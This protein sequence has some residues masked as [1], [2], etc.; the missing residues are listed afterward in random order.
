[1]SITHEPTAIVPAEGVRA[2]YNETGTA[3]ATGIFVKDTAGSTEDS[4]AVC[5]DGEIAKGVTM[6]AIADLARGDVQVS[7]RAVMT[8]G[9]A[10]AR[11]VEV[12]ANASG[13]AITAVSGDWVAGRSVSAAGALADEITIELLGP[14]S[15]YF[16]A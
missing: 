12:T 9:A 6:A 14:G 15:G 13:Q 3:I 4:V 1:M 7:G 2:G 11:A 16:K 8:A 10:V 5:G